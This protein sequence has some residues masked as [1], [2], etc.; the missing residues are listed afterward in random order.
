MVKKSKKA[1]ENGGGTT[2]E[3]KKSSKPSSSRSD[4][5]KKSKDG[6]GDITHKSAKR[7]KKKSKKDLA[8]N[9]NNNIGSS[10]KKATKSPPPPKK[11]TSLSMSEKKKKKKKDNKSNNVNNNK[12]GKK[13]KQQQQQQQQQHQKPK[14]DNDDDLP[15]NDSSSPSSAKNDEL[16]VDIRMPNSLT[17]IPLQDETDDDDHDHDDDLHDSQLI[18]EA[19]PIG[20]VLADGGPNDDALSDIGDGGG[21]NVGTNNENSE[22][23]QADGVVYNP[24][25]NDVCFDDRGHPGTKD[26]IAVVRVAVEKF[27]DGTTEYS[28][29]VY[30]MIKKRLKGRRFLI[31]NTRRKKSERTSWREATKPEVIELFGIC[32]NEERRKHRDGIFDDGDDE[33]DVDS[34][35]QDSA[36]QSDE[37]DDDN[38]KIIPSSV[39]KSLAKARQRSKKR[40]KNDEGKG[41]TGQSKVPN[42][43]RSTRNKGVPT[44]SDLSASQ[45]ML[46]LIVVER[47]EAE[48]IARWFDDGDVLEKGMAAEQKL[49]VLQNL[50]KANNSHTVKE[51][52]EKLDDLATR[53]KYASM[54][55][56]LD[57]LDKVEVHMTEYYQSLSEEDGSEPKLR[58]LSGGNARHNRSIPINADSSEGSLHSRADDKG[59]RKQYRGRRQHNENFSIST[60]SYSSGQ[61][62]RGIR[63]SYGEEALSGSSYDVLSEDET[64]P[65]NDDGQLNS[66]SYDEGEEGY[67]ELGSQSLKDDEIMSASLGGASKPERV[68]QV[69]TDKDD[70]MSSIGRS[71]PGIYGS[72]SDGSDDEGTYEDIND[73]EEY[74]RS[75]Q[76][77]TSESAT[78]VT[79]ERRPKDVSP[80]AK[81]EQFFDR[82]QHFFELRRKV[83]ER[84]DMIDPSGKCQ[85]LKVK[86]HSGGIEKK[87]GKFK[88]EYQQRGLSDKLVRN[89]DD[90]Y[91]AANHAQ[92]ELKRVL[93]QM[94]NEVNGF[95]DTSCI[96]MPALKPRDRAYEKVKQEYNDRDPG[97]P[98]SWLYD[99]VRASVICKSNKQLSDVNKWLGK[100]VQIVASKN[101]FSQPCFNG[102]RDLL[103]HVSIPFQEELAHVCEVQ[104]HHKDMKTLDE[105]FG[106]P[107]H[108]EY[109]RSCFAGSLRSQ[110]DT[111][112]D[113]A[114]LNNYG[115]I[116]GQLMMKLMK[117]KDLDQLRLFAWLCRD[118]L[119]EFDHSLQIYRRILLL[120]T[121][122]LGDDH[123]DL[124]STYLS[125][126]LVLGAMGDTDESLAQ[127]ERALEI[128]EGFLG[129]DHIELAKTY[130]EIGRMLS[131]KGDFAGA[132][133][134][135]EKALEI[136]ETKLGRDHF[137][138][139]ASL[140]DIG[141]AHVERGD[142]KSAESEYRKAL[143]IQETLLGNVHSDVASTRALIGTTLC[144]RGDVGKAMEEHRLALSIR[145]TNLGKNHP[146]TAESHTDIGIVLSLKG[147]YEVAEKRHRKAL[148]IREAT[149]GKEDED[150][151]VSLSHLGHVL[152]QKGDFDGAIKELQRAQKIREHNFGMDH[153]RTAMSYIDLGNVYLKI[154][155]HEKALKEFRRAKVVCESIL[156]QLHPDTALAYNSLGN[157]LNRGGEH[158]AALVEHRKALSIFEQL[159][160]KNHPITA[161]GYQSLAE[162]LTAMGSK[163]EALVEHR[164]ALAVRAIVLAKD[165]P[166]TAVSCS[167]IG[168]LLS[169]KGDLLGALV[170]YKQALA[171][172]ASLCGED[173][174]DAATAQIQV[175]KIFAA[176]GELEDAFEEIDQAKAIR[177]STLGREHIE[178]GRV[179]GLLGTLHSMLGEFS[180]A[181]DAHERA[182]KILKKNLGKEHEEVLM[183]KEKL[184]MAEN[185]EEETQL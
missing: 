87:N 40:S 75:E 37:D 1:E 171:I 61:R 154:N 122:E 128:Q 91:D 18:E 125:I 99:V 82:L 60:E 19:P 29:P 36:K 22:Q 124:A 155:D 72:D 71:T 107:K 93:E 11:K 165:H 133:K 170:A 112:H 140:Q 123:E 116:G 135:H 178:T 131:K 12:K 117:S 114:M 168:T 8:N 110:E 108:Y 68:I 62:E 17:R 59:P 21:A 142:F 185:E 113:L 172:T 177:E 143:K 56:L 146:V 132:L 83:E 138:V 26:Y 7:T 147:D 134:Q 175:G 111:L 184:E 23:E 144:Q 174:P 32:F 35:L 158:K 53:L 34:S 3:K 9:N 50:A 156:G 169:S 70:D 145:E 2:A 13:S 24:M 67:G 41:D 80:N 55:P 6:S 98:E 101:R 43:T 163:E 46:Q 58:R 65:L 115:D 4:K 182:L 120:Q 141:R 76:S 48:V 126:G 27:D 179:Y 96:V 148:R 159:L 25:E 166:D 31:K 94:V 162:T 88:K 176:Q 90:L 151:A 161:T 57:V 103:F 164:R 54:A 167:R 173:H 150:C 84:S 106:L 49:S 100:N 139:I 39:N 74:S 97:P 118:K 121:K 45:R 180:E 5:S 30:K 73:E 20:E 127:L 129:S 47:E 109:F 64:Y 105:Q 95:E 149:K 130:G 14:A 160:G 66:R 15:V 92:A 86:I 38:D 69:G 85:N 104:V 44:T 89:L 63:D 33:S 157:A 136:R 81:V 102:Y 77:D 42:G 78:E 137:L 119:D 51:E 153:P 183:I 16:S 79:P 152:C 28:P 10:S 52:L 181:S